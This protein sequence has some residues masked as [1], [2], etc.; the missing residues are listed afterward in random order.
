MR[1]KKRGNFYLQSARIIRKR[2]VQKK[3]QIKK[4]AN[5]GE[6]TVQTLGVAWRCV[7]ADVAFVGDVALHTM[8]QKNYNITA[9]AKADA[10]SQSHTLR[11]QLEGLNV[12]ALTFG[13]YV[14][15]KF[16]GTFITQSALGLD[17]SVSYTDEKHVILSLGEHGLHARVANISKC[18]KFASCVGR[19]VAFG[20]HGTLEM[21]DGGTLAQ[22][23][24]SLRKGEYFSRAHAFKACADASTLHGV[25]FGATADW[26]ALSGNYAGMAYVT[27]KGNVAVF[28]M[29]NKRNAYN[30]K[31]IGASLE[32]SDATKAG[33]AL[34]FAQAGA[35]KGADKGK[36]KG[37]VKK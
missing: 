1:G 3:R 37:K 16:A 28:S 36:G 33:A 21:R 17:K 9:L 18:G 22:F 5:K 32:A 11:V 23:C 35:D 10:V 7:K 6:T 20:T 13:A 4:T 8:A 27:A 29:E 30:A 24:E 26:S 14:S 2:R 25:G 31:Q 15:A 34:V 19:V 12:G